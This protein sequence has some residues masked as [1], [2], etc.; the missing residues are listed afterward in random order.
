[1]SYNADRALTFCIYV[2]TSFNQVLI[3]WPWTVNI[4]K[5]FAVGFRKHLA[6][7]KS[8]VYTIFSLMACSGGISMR[9]RAWSTDP[10][11]NNKSK[12]IQVWELPFQMPTH[13]DWFK[14]CDSTAKWRKLLI[15]NWRM[16][17]L[18]PS[19][20]KTKPRSTNKI[21]KA[22]WHHQESISGFVTSCQAGEGG[23]AWAE[24]FPSS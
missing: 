14:E 17:S 3:Y 18:K 10:D 9:F 19:Q 4:V 5:S 11:S 20:I 24:Q 12:K 8:K 16:A 7:L 21:G 2:K 23:L 1:M 15:F 22:H 6:G 13:S